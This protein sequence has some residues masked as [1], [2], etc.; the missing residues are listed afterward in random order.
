MVPSPEADQ[1]GELVFRHES[2]GAAD[3]IVQHGGRQVLRIAPSARKEFDGSTVEVV[4]G[5]L[6]VVPPGPMP[7]D[8]SRGL[9]LSHGDGHDRPG[10][11]RQCPDGAHGPRQPEGVGDDAGR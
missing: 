6:G 4:D 1:G 9:H 7:A 10:E 11:E 8:F 2:G 3:Q 5:A